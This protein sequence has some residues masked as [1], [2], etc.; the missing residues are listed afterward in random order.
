MSPDRP[1]TPATG[2]ETQLVPETGVS[3][4]AARGPCVV[5]DGDRA[6]CSRASR[7][8]G[9]A[10]FEVMSATDGRAALRQIFASSGHPSLLL[11]AIELPGMS[12]IELAARVTAARP[13]VRVLLMSPDAAAVERARQH[14]QLVRAVLLKPYTTETFRAAV[15]DALAPDP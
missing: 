11:C 7:L 10:G 12:G 6:D 13:G 8:L 9:E 5:V 15:A 14:A 2:T 1:G 4:G 3:S